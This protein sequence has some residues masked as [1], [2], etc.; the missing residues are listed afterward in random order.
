MPDT[1]AHQINRPSLGSPLIPGHIGPR[2]NQPDQISYFNAIKT[3]LRDSSKFTICRVI[4]IGGNIASITI[5]GRKNTDHLASCG[6]INTTQTAVTFTSTAVLFSV[7]IFATA[8]LANEN[9]VYFGQIY[10]QGFVTCIVVSI[11]ATLITYFMGDILRLCGQQS[12]TTKILDD[13]NSLYLPAVLANMIFMHNIQ[14]LLAKQHFTCIAIQSIIYSSLLIFLS[15]ALLYGRY[16]LPEMG[17]RGVGLA[18]SISSWSSVTIIT[19]YLLLSP[20]YKQYLLFHFHCSIRTSNEVFKNIMYKGLP[21]GLSSGLETI[22]LAI[23]GAFLG[24]LGKNS[25][26][27][28]TP[29]FNISSLLTPISFGIAQIGGMLVRRSTAQNKF[30][31]ARVFG[32][33]SILVGLMLP[34]I[35]MCLFLSAP[36]ELLSLFMS[37]ET[38]KMPEIRQ[39]SKII[40]YL[41]GAGTI[42]DAIR[43]VSVGAVRGYNDTSFAMMS[44]LLNTLLIGTILSA[45][46]GFE[47]A[48]SDSGII[49]GRSISFALGAL[50]MFSYWKFKGRCIYDESS[51][52][53]NSNQSMFTNARLWIK[54]LLLLQ[55]NRYIAQAHHAETPICA[56]HQDRTTVETSSAVAVARS[57]QTPTIQYDPNRL[58]NNQP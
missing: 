26:A 54:F 6:L 37:I 47:T 10:R 45:T 9:R 5:L 1:L 58:D 3:I 27:A 4:Y 43:V 24:L 40:L 8:A 46:L 51:F 17:S 21:I 16:G 41:Y 52:S 36:E 20:H 23:M 56:R 42:P 44:A 48:L 18:N 53:Q 22:N 11:P 35:S 34:I 39:K 32:N 28:S 14:I 31:E 30:T 7:G 57:E 25:L 19:V 12:H 38:A 13:Y 55:P 33:C 15:N 2:D 49:A 50:V 29:A